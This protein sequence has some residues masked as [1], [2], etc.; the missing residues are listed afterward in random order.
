M[1][2]PEFV[3][4]IPAD[5]V[6]V[7]RSNPWRPDG[8]VPDR[9][10]ELDGWQPDEPGFG[11][12]GPDHGYSLLLARR[13]E[14]RLVLTEG[15]KARDV[16]RGATAIANRR[17]AI[18]ARGPMVHDLTLALTVF[19]FLGEAPDD[20]VELRKP[21]FAEVD[22]HL[23]YQERRRLAAM[24]PEWVLRRSHHEV[25]ELA[26]RDWRILFSAEAPPA[27]PAPPAAS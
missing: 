26:A 6:R 5:E 21:L 13:F 10:A 7:Y 11:N 27:A 15:E 22:F 19:G 23:H 20:L 12:P 4:P 17:S 25:A 16:L 9:P 2:A 1:A 3:P 8:W 14:D 18:F 24:V